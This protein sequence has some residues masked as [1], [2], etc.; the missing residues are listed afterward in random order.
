M[1]IGVALAQH[2]DAYDT[3][4]QKIGK[5]FQQKILILS[6]DEFRSNLFARLWGKPLIFGS[7][8]LSMTGPRIQIAATRKSFTISSG[9]EE[10]PSSNQP[11]PDSVRRIRPRMISRVSGR[12]TLR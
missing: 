9:V 4:E 8:E 1:I 7:M 12:T 11:M 2:P 6:A 3:I 5:A 10:Y